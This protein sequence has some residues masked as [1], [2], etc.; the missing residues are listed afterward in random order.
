MMN[1]KRKKKTSFFSIIP[2]N[3][4]MPR[5]RGGGRGGRGRGGSR[6]G[7]RIP[8]GGRFRTASSRK[9]KSKGQSNNH[10]HGGGGGG[11]YAELMDLEDNVF[12]PEI[13]RK[14]PKNSMRSL[15][16][17]PNRQML[18]EAR[19]TDEHVEETIKQPL[20]KRPI[21]FVKA[22][23]VYD[24]SAALKRK[25]EAEEETERDGSLVDGLNMLNVGKR[26]GDEDDNEEDQDEEDEEGEV[27][28][29]DDIQDEEVEEDY[30]SEEIEV[31]QEASIEVMEDYQEVTSSAP[32]FVIDENGDFESQSHDK[33][34]T[35]Q[36]LSKSNL[37][38]D[39]TL[40]V[41]K[42]S[43]QTSKAHDGDTFTSLPKQ[44]SKPKPKHSEDESY[45]DFSGYKEYIAQ[46]MGEM[47]ESED[48]ES[49]TNFDIMASSEEEIEE[50]EQ[51][52]L[53]EEGK[54]PEYGFL[55]EDFEFDVSQLFIS[56]MRYGIQNQYFVRNYE[57]AGSD[58]DF[59]WV[60]EDDL[61]DFVLMK[62][63][64]QHRLASFMKY[65]TKGLLDD[66]SQEMESDIY[67][68][69]TSED[70]SEEIV[71][72][73]GLDD[74]IAFAKQQHLQQKSTYY[75]PTTPTTSLK[76]SGKGRKKKLALD[77]VDLDM[78][79]RESLQDQ[80]QIHRQARKDRKNR[81]EQETLYEG[82]KSN[83]LLVKYPYSM[84]IKDFR[85]EFELFLHDTDRQTMSFPPLDPHGNKTVCKLASCYNMKTSKNGG[86]GLKS[87]IK[88]AKSR[89]TFHYLPRYDQIGSILKQRPI[90]NRTD[91]K[92]PRDEI[93]RTDGNAKKDRQRGG[94]TSKAHVK[95]GDIV[96]SNAPEIDRSNIGRQLLEKLGWVKGEG[97]GAHGN[98]GISEP[99]LATVKKSKTGL[100][101]T[102][103][104]TDLKISS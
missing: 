55:P 11:A 36:L 96:G 43:L 47:S 74:I 52:D 19:Y 7:S 34:S 49:D 80:Y 13:G 3:V 70:E 104:H 38:Y 87:Y 9:K 68:S 10:R 29:G 27:G 8:S 30:I 23:E 100:K 89:K 79:M 95:E 39:S 54:D 21:E 91:V 93:I 37:D 102:D 14:V 22:K 99:V 61:F 97:L 1:H 92:R 72:D 45:D 32:D 24:P 51:L 28:Q 88:V 6:G 31:D 103:K 75:D 85:E 90:F 101:S 57:L 5:K 82:L 64:K 12:I 66:D 25:K 46:I 18:A 98:K 33:V 58:S 78:E 17:R 35:K 62:G 42:V 71:D 48:Y 59:T 15:S 65:M 40:T 26:E 73:D 41:G 67:I 2:K 94:H 16:R 60:D 84:H 4:L 81:K 77:H 63:V 50:G 44:R 20:R 86:N 53:E 56:N 83:D 76:T 69:E